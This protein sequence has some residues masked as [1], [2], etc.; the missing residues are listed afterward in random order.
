MPNCT[1]CTWCPDH[2][3]E[4]EHLLIPHVGCVTHPKPWPPPPPTCTCEINPET[5]EW[6]HGDPCPRHPR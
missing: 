2:T 1:V 3:G 5:G 4:N 6:T